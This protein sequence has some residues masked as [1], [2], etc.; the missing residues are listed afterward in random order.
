MVELFQF[1]IEFG[2]LLTLGLVQLALEYQA[3]WLVLSWGV[4]YWLG[5]RHGR[6]K[7]MKRF[8]L[9]ALFALSLPGC[10]GFYLINSALGKGENLTPD[11]IK[12]YQATGSD[13]YG[14]FQIGGPPPA[15]NTNWII[16]PKNAP[17]KP[18][19]GDNCHVL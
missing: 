12:A 6:V 18:A 1:A 19:F 13:V 3:Y 11:Q 10:S 14:C 7:K 5:F 17:K 9:I 4:F 2:L 15:G 16:I 8:L